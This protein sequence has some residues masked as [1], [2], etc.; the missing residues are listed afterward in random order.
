MAISERKTTPEKT[1]RNMPSLCLTWILLASWGKE[2][3][4]KQRNANVASNHQYV[5]CMREGKHTESECKHIRQC[6]TS[7]IHHMKL[8]HL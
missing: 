8:T 6:P 3:G 1:K 4:R 2:V 7:I 5:F